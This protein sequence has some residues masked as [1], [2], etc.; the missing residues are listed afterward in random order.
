LIEEEIG[1]GE[2]ARRRTVLQFDVV[3]PPEQGGRVLSAVYLDGEA[4]GFRA[5]SSG[6]GSPH[7]S[8]FHAGLEVE[9]GDPIPEGLIQL[10]IVH[11][12]LKLDES[13]EVTWRI[14]GS[15]EDAEA[16][17]APIT[18]HP[19]ESVEIDSGLSLALDEVV[20]TD[21]LTAIRVA[22]GEAPPGVT[23]HRISHVSPDQRNELSL[24]DDRRRSYGEPWLR[25][26]FWRP[27]EQPEPD[28]SRLTFDPVQALARRMTLEVPAMAVTEPASATFNVTLPEGM[29]PSLDATDAPWPASQP[30]EID[31][32]VQIG[33]YD[34]RFSK[35]QLAEVNGTMTLM[36][37]SRAYR[38]SRRGQWL[39][40]FRFAAVTRPDG[41]RVTVPAPQALG[42]AGPA[43]GTAGP[44]P[45]G[46]VHAATIRLDVANPNTGFVQPGRYHVEVDGLVVL[47]KGPWELS[48]DLPGP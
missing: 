38:P 27:S 42:L 29:T 30:W 17:P 43:Y 21:R 8:V 11:A 28:V 19:Q 47:R 12:N 14:P 7:A 40:G 6:G 20:L 24:E 1:S 4:A 3:R 33:P 2:G 36:L 46:G 16:K 13:W 26:V 25:D 9:Q 35:A 10:N 34:L 15:D 41:R 31:I 18:L 22:L 5:G 48:W 32:P 23:L 39:A 45:D 44:V 37:T